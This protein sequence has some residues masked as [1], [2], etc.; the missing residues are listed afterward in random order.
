MPTDG[1]LD[2]LELP[3]RGVAAMKKFYGAA[4]G[5]S[6]VDY[7][8][9]YVEFDSG[10]RKGGFNAERKAAV[11]GGALAAD[12]VASAA[13]RR[14]TPS[15]ATPGSFQSCVIQRESS[16]NPRAVN[17]SSGAG[18][19]TAS[20]RPPGTASVFLACQRMRPWLSR[21][22]PSPRSTHSPGPA[23]GPRTTAAE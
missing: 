3:A 2:Y 4:F 12:T 17:P 14:A 15:G 20:C 13:A 6:F 23:L 1:A 9:D 8:P 22:T 18:A 7:G 19:C 21:T 5:W 16:G 11:S 10:G